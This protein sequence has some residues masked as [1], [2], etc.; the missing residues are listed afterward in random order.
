MNSSLSFQQLHEQEELYSMWG[1]DAPHV[2]PPTALLHFTIA[3]LGFVTF[4][5]ACKYILIPER[6][7]IP[8]QYPY[9]GLVK[10]L[11]GIEENKVSLSTAI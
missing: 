7:S 10:E 4:G 2:P 5:F 3:T 11:G 9:D 8:R 6:P 1:P